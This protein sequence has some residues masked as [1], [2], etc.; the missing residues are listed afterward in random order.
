MGCAHNPAPVLCPLRPNLQGGALCDRIWNQLLNFSVKG[1]FAVKYRRLFTPIVINGMELK[2]R[3][4]MPAMH[5][6]Y[7]EN[8]FCTKRFSEYYWK[9][10]EGGAG[11]LIVGSCRFDEYGAKNNSMSLASDDTI[12]GWKA[13]TD[14]VHARG[15]KVAVQLYHAGRYVPQRDVPCGEPALSPSAVYCPYTRE[16]PPEMT[17]EQIHAVTAA[18]ARGAQRARS[19]GFDAVEIIASAGYLIPQF[20]SPVTNRRTDAYG[21]SWENRCRFPLEVIRAVRQAV[22]PDYPILM[23]IC[24]ND[25]IP[26]SNTNEEWAAFAPLAQEAGVDLLNVTVGWHE[27]RVPQITGEVS[28]GGLTYTGKAIRDAVTIPVAIGG[29]V[30]R[31]DTAEKVLALGYGDLITMGRALL[32]DPDLPNK[33]LAEEEDTIRPCMGCNQGCLANTFFDRPITCLVNPLCGREE[34]ISLPA[35]SAPMRILVVG[36]GPA[37]CEAAFRLAQRGHAV[38]LWEKSGQLGGQLALAARMIARGDFRKL[39]HYYEKNLPR[40]GVQVELGRE[41][42]LDAIRDGGFASV[43][44]ATGGVP[45]ETALPTEPG[46]VPVMTAGQV[47][48]GEAFPGKRVVVIGG[49][50]IGCET[51]RLLAREGSLS[52]AQLFHLSANH[53]E[54]P[55]RLETLLNTSA[56]QVTLIEKGPKIGFGYESGTGWPALGDLTRLGVTMLKNATVTSIAAGCIRCQ[57]RDKDGGVTT[58]TIECDTVV[59]ASGVHPDSAL[60]DALNAAGI[61]ARAIGNAYKL[62]RAISAIRAGAEAGCTL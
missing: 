2:N 13:F 29:R 23:R 59:A 55:Q 5:H 56:R 41:G 25:F 16:T 57:V 1:V 27:S 8:G 39:I 46:C 62:G 11:L 44:V 35:C 52:P 45:N 10:A 43:L 61:P 32:A 51:A 30:N 4:V 48:R 9:R 47:I 60:A 20:L 24:G 53:A 19:A 18:W 12:P 58:R 54:S 7:T 21:G 31:A 15:A 17:V 14:G 36:G 49:S 3:I 6:L 33:A 38:T 50:Y 26:G 22:G 40:M 28:W 34:E 37:G 42:T